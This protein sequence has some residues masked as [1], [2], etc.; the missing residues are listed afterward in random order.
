MSVPNTSTPNT[1]TPDAS[2]PD[3]SGADSASSTHT[4][5]VQTEEGGRE[6]EAESGISLR[7]ALRRHGHSPH[8]AVTDIANCGGRG[9]CGLCTVEILTGAPPPTQALDRTLSGMGVG[10]LSCLV[11]VDRDMTVR[12]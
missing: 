10:R 2:T 12:L 5:T 1:S 6:F 4:I 8:N 11:T 9:H 3:A 7:Q